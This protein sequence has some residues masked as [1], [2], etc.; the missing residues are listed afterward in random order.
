MTLGR[1]STGAIKIK[2][3][4]PGLRAV[5]CACCDGG[6]E[7]IKCLRSGGFPYAE[8]I[9]KE[10]FDL[11]LAGGTLTIQMSITSS[12]G[13]YGGGCSST[14]SESISVPPDECS[15]VW[16]ARD[17]ESGVPQSDYQY[18]CNTFYLYNEASLSIHLIRRENDPSYYLQVTGW[19]QCAFNFFTTSQ[20]PCGVSFNS[21]ASIIR[22][23]SGQSPFTFLGKAFSFYDSPTYEATISLAFS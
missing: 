2:T 20:Y 3:D 13:Y 6:D 15:L 21:T 9:S 11:W 1:S 10:N 4:S 17:E 5:E 12:G 8:Q 23:G 22:G 7:E 19:V 14:F 18:P 16:F